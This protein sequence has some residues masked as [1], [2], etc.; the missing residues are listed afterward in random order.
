VNAAGTS[1]R[2]SAADT[3]SPANAGESTIGQLGRYRLIKS[4]GVG[5]QAEVFKARYSGP[6]GF[7]RTVVLK[8]ILPGNCEDPDF[9]RMFAAEARIL[10]MLH[11]PNIVQAYD[12]GES[13][14]ALFL[15]LEYVDGPSLGRLMRA[16]RSATRP[17]P[18]P[19]AAHFAREVC[20]A[21]DYVHSL[22]D[23]DGA[24]MN[25]VHRD[26]TPSNIVLTSAG[27]LKLLDFGIAKYESTEVQTHH[28]A[29]KGK[30]A[31][32]APEAIEGRPVDARVDLFSVGVVLHEMLTLSPLFGADHDLAILRKVLEMPI[33]PPS[34]T[35][36]D[37]PPELDAIVMK[38]LQR[39]PARR[40]ASAAEMVRDLDG[41][42]V[43]AQL[44][45][46]DVI[47]F[48]REIEPLLNPPRI[49]IEA[50]R[51]TAMG[52]MATE[53]AA[54]PTKSDFVQ[55]L[56]RSPLGRLFFGREKP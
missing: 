49:S 29:I 56:R 10:G 6:G 33:R 21:L 24:P 37:I 16:L 46:D 22:R 20:R 17:L 1:V 28:R 5:G 38:A 11:H 42:V 50:L 8:R 48:L 12:V 26:V 51:A 39:D 36:P 32:V 19:F 55:R 27:S 35:R 15:V 31:Y 18:A 52:E 54:P 13:D 34:E 3:P 30:P 23:S 4:L 25:V 40:Y 41:F 45:V 9:V 7:E 2:A 44:H 53:P 14:G 43:D 47:R